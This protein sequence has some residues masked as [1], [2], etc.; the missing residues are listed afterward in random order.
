MKYKIAAN[1]DEMVAYII[2]LHFRKHDVFPYSRIGEIMK[3]LE[4]HPPGDMC[5]PGTDSC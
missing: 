2:K 5:I 1:I 3:I 4:Q